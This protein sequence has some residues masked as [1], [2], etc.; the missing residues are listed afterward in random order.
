VLTPRRRRR[1]SNRCM[2]SMVAYLR[3]R[4]DESDAQRPAADDGSWYRLAF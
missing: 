4:L 3:I 1:S 2:G